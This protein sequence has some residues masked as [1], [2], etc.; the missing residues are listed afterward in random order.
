MLRDSV[1]LACIVLAIFAFLALWAA[2]RSDYRGLLP[3]ALAAVSCAELFAQGTSLYR[4]GRPEYL[5]PI[6]PALDFLRAQQRPFRIA[7][8]DAVLFPQSNIFAE[9][10][11]VRTHDPM[12]RRD[13]VEFLDLTVGYRPTDYFKKISDVNQSVLDFLNVRFLIAPNW[14]LTPGKKWRLVYSGWDATIFENPHVLERVFAPQGVRTVRWE[15]SNNVAQR[16]A[17]RHGILHLNSQAAWKQEAL[18]LD[19]RGEEMTWPAGPQGKVT[20]RNYRETTNGATFE[21]TNRRSGKQA[22]VVASLSKMVVGLRGR[23]PVCLC[24]RRLPTAP[25]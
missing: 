10:E 3:F 17:V 25:F 9:M 20:V 24:Q 23:A 21:A 18:I 4:F 5:Y 12:E 6:T 13:Y 16:Q 15:D 19:R 8:Y 14:Q 1:T 11:D 2:V 7:G 22:I